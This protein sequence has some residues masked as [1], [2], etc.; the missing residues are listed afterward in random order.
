[1]KQL[2]SSTLQHIYKHEKVAKKKFITREHLGENLLK[3]HRYCLK[4]LEFFSIDL[5]TFIIN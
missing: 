4:G 2:H 1:M 5:Q 3:R